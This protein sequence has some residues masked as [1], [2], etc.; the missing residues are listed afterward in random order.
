MG[1]LLVAVVM[2]VPGGILGGLS[3]FATMLRSK[4]T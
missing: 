2:F 3:R 1:V 4:R